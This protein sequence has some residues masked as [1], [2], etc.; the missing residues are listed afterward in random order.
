MHG[1]V[2]HSHAMY[3]RVQFYSTALQYKAQHFMWRVW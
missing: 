1:M 2:I 3:V